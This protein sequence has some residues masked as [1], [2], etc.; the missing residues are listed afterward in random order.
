[1][2]IHCDDIDCCDFCTDL[3][4]DVNPKM[5][6]AMYAIYKSSEDDGND[7]AE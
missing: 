5:F 1:M 2:S 7:S 6:A 3:S 4:C